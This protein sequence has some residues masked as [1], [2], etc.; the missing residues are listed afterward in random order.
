[1]LHDRRKNFRVEWN[2]PGTIYNR[3]GESGYRCIVKDLS[4]GGVKI[5]GV[6]VADVPDQF[7][8]HIAGDSRTRR[9]EVLWR[10]A[11]TLGV[12]FTDRPALTDKS[13]APHARRAK[14]GAHV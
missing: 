7:T 2:S 9:C 5:S 11:D 13:I 14:R 8:L 3:E 12:K 1:M 6:V 4:N 10:K